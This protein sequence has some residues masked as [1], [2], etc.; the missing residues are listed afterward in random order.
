MSQ[1]F[2]LHD[3]RSLAAA[4]ADTDPAPAA[5]APDVTPPAADSAAT[6]TPEA[7]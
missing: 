6:E 2:Q 5:P 4:E 1:L 3:A 7:F